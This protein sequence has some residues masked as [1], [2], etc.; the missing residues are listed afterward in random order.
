MPHRSP[1]FLSLVSLK[2]LQ[3]DIQQLRKHWP[4]KQTAGH[5]LESR[6]NPTPA[7]FWHQSLCYSRGVS[8][9]ANGCSPPSELSYVQS[10][11]RPGKCC[12]VAGAARWAKPAPGK[13]CHQRPKAALCCIQQWGSCRHKSRGGL[14]NSS[15]SSLSSSFPRNTNSRI[16]GTCWRGFTLWCVKS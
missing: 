8:P 4:G 5:L 6:A 9:G 7:F 11:P 12:A 1:C 3:S 15:R 13:C 14:G 16:S 2:T 10:P